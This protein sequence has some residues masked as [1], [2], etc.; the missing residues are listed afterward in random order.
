M[1]QG[2]KIRKNKMVEKTIPLS[3]LFISFS[4]SLFTPSP[5]PLP[6]EKRNG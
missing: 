1:T 2:E 4:S 5:Y 6:E 3:N